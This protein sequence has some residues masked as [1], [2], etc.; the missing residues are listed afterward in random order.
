[1]NQLR[2]KNVAT[3]PELTVHTSALDYVNRK[4]RKR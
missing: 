1:M 4:E 3:V 2:G